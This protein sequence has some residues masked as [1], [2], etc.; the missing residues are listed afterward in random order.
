MKANRLAIAALL[1]VACSS[2]QCALEAPRAGPSRPTLDGFRMGKDPR[3]PRPQFLVGVACAADL[4]AAQRR[5]FA[6]VAEQ[7]IAKVESEASSRYEERTRVV[8]DR[9]ESEMSIST[10]SQVNVSSQLD[11][12]GLVRVV[13]TAA[14]DQ[15]FC[16]LACLSRQEAAAH[17]RRTLDVLREQADVLLREISQHVDNHDVLAA[18]PKLKRLREQ[19]ALHREA[20]LLLEAF[21][22]GSSDGLESERGLLSAYA[23]LRKQ[24]ARLV[25]QIRCS[26]A[27]TDSAASTAIYA[28]I[29]A[30]VVDALALRD[31]RTNSGV[32][33]ELLSGVTH[34]LLVEAS[35][36]CEAETGPTCQM[37]ATVTLSV[38]G[39]QPVRSGVVSSSAT[40]ASRP[41]VEVASRRS[42]QMLGDE[43]EHLVNDWLGEE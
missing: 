35:L 38:P 2:R 16:V 25:V 23:A 13:D 21:S 15:K 26:L 8:A 18:F 19:C 39:G 43:V 17:Q 28:A 11:T 42:A 31:V 3:C 1:V 32:T 34:E 27:S 24:R 14:D 5:A 4:A 41:S 6:M 37:P 40:R 33:H 30:R 29:E 20:T 7:V 12:A 22:P 36:H 10:S 9:R